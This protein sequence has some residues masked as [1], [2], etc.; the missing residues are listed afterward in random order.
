MQKENY[1][2]IV[3]CFG[4]VRELNQ[5]SCAAWECAIHYSKASLDYQRYFGSM[6]VQLNTEVADFLLTQHPGSILG[7]LENFS[8]DVAEI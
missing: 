3:L 6:G 2:N 1:Q 7:I 4:Q 5:A 8:P